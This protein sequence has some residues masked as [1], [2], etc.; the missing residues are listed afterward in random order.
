[1]SQMNNVRQAI[2]MTET[3]IRALD[4]LIKQH[5]TMLDLIQ[6]YAQGKI[7]CRY[8][9][10]RGGASPEPLFVAWK[11]TPMTRKLGKLSKYEILPTERVTRFIKRYGPFDGTQHDV[12]LLI[13]RIK[14]LIERRKGL[15]AVV[16]RFMHAISLSVRAATLVRQEQERGFLPE[17]YDLHDRHLERVE[18]WKIQKAEKARKIAEQDARS[19]IPDPADYIDLFELPPQDAFDDGRE[20]LP[21]SYVD[22]DGNYVGP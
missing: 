10:P 19:A 1:M 15:S 18:K 7:S 4:T 12:R 21:E 5:S 8:L 11:W 17:M 16:G 2:E 14:H 13:G 22:E 3:E 9:R 20:A 6:P